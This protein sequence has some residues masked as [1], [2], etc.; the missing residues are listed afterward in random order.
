MMGGGFGGWGG[1]GFLGG[2]GM[3][4]MWIIPLLIIG[5]IVWA[6]VEGTRRRDDH[7]TAVYYVQPS[8]AA[9]GPVTT[10]TPAAIAASAARAIL[11]ERYARGDIGREEYLERGGDLV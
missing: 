4:F 6:I 11:D 1:G 7:P 3:I 2:L 8:V 5:L 9:Q 10:Q